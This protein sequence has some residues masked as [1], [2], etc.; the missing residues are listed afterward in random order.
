MKSVIL[1]FISC[2]H[3]RFATIKVVKCPSMLQRK[4]IDMMGYTKLSNIGRK[5]IKMG[6]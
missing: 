6:S 1:A 3:H 5:R 2:I 4:E